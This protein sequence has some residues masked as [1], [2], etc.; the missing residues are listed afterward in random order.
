MGNA[1]RLVGSYLDNPR[2]PE[3]RL[4]P[5]AASN[6]A[7]LNFLEHLERRVLM[8]ATMHNPTL[9][10]VG[11]ESP[12][13]AQL[14]MG[15]RPG[16]A[17]L[18]GATAPETGALFGILW[19]ANIGSL[20]S[21]YSATIDKARIETRGPIMATYVDSPN[22]N[23]TPFSS[24]TGLSLAQADDLIGGN[25]GFDLLSEVEADDHIR[26]RDN[27]DSPARNH[28]NAFTLGIG[29]ADCIFQG[30]SE[31]TILNEDINDTADADIGRAWIEAANSD[32]THT[33]SPDSDPIDGS[34]KFSMIT[35]RDSNP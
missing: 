16:H 22:A 34:L 26:I 35:R 7:A 8:S 13:T 1:F 32:T 9:H 20:R 5:D 2:R 3:H 27:G 18:S 33:P 24:G 17:A 25:K 31:N 11:S 15:L 30:V 29:G 21:D 19:R 28:R 4:Q 23:H 10:L 14:V 6:R 12:D